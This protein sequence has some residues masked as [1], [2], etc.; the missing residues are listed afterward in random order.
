MLLWPSCCRCS[1][2]WIYEI[3]GRFIPFQR[4]DFMPRYFLLA[5][6]ICLF[7]AFAISRIRCES[8]K[9]LNSIATSSFCAFSMKNALFTFCF[10]QVSNVFLRDF[11]FSSKYAS[12]KNGKPNKTEYQSDVFNCFH[13]LFAKYSFPTLFSYSDI[14]V[15]FCVEFCHNS[16][17][18]QF[19]KFRIKIG[20]CEMFQN[21]F[22]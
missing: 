1:D 18:M 15:K 6:V 17:F 20:V 7:E 4:N 10:A 12:C 11:V 3:F 16:C 21:K 13:V 19:V 5:F 9:A 14:G 22:N 2:E 8:S